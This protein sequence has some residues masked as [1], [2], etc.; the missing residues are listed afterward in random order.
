MKRVSCALLC[1]LFLIA[2]AFSQEAQTVYYAVGEWD[3]PRDKWDDFAAFFEKYEKPVM[4]R[5]LTEGVIVEWGFAAEGLHD[6]DG[7]THSTWTGATSLAALEKAQQAYYLSLGDNADDRE[8]EFA[9]MITKHRDAF[10]R[11]VAYKTRSVKLTGGYLLGSMVQIDP[12]KGRE[13][14]EAWEAYQKPI[15]DQLL[16]DGTIIGYTLEVEHFHTSAPGSFTN[17]YVLEDLAAEEKVEAAFD[18]AWEKL[19]AQDRDARM[20]LY[21]SF[22]DWSSHRDYMNRI[23]YMQAR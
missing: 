3:V 14:R 6:P 15:Y 20:S 22:G 2:P 1:V 18:A 9:S 17:W 16:A 7:Y 10:T 21:E 5:M 8:N 4:E 11:T 12:A 23:I 19:S 13:Y